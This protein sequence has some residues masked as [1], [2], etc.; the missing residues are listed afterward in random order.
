[1]LAIPW[2]LMDIATYGVGLFTPV[3]LKSIEISGR[4][5]GL[6]AHDL[7]VAKGSGVIDLFLLFGYLLGICMVP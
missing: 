7:A 3:I 1:V 4:A 2:F 6:V 5:L